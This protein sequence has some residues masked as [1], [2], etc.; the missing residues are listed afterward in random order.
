MTILFVDPLPVDQYHRLRFSEPE[1][2]R[3]EAGDEM[4]RR[5]RRL[6]ARRLPGAHQG[7]ATGHA[8]PLAQFVAGRVLAG[9]L[10]EEQGQTLVQGAVAPADVPAALDRIQRARR[11]VR[12]RPPM[13]HPKARIVPVPAYMGGLIDDLRA[14][15][16]C[17][18]AEA[19]GYEVAVVDLA[20]VIAFQPF[21]RLPDIA[22]VERLI[23]PSDPGS[24]AA[25][26][27]AQNPQSGMSCYFN[28][29]LGAWA[30]DSPNHNLSVVD[31]FG[32]EVEPGMMCV[33]FKFAVQ[34]SV[35]KVL[36]YRDRWYLS[37]GYHRAGA[38]VRR[39][40]ALAPALVGDAAALEDLGC[41]GHL[42]IDS[43]L[44]ERP[45]GLADYFDDRVAMELKVPGGP[46][47]YV[48]HASRIT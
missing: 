48:V 12:E 19:Q 31:V 28:A 20:R 7:L 27:F 15:P 6:L 43:F 22:I 2:G 42:P 23:V 40:V 29:V 14:T 46:R 21:V 1:R 39:G 17:Q 34:P 16:I 11:A 13:D 5:S 9:W 24:I 18:E 47:R 35:L 10:S 8:P 4:R 25:V 26:A 33:G 3:S 36:R 41:I 30:V 38:L 44:G 45:P 37:D 32:E